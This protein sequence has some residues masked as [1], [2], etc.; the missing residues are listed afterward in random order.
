[1]IFF[2]VLALLAPPELVTVTGQV[3]DDQ[4]GEPVARALVKAPWFCPGAELFT[5]ESGEFRFQCKKI[6]N[7]GDDVSADIGARRPGYQTARHLLKPS[8]SE[9]RQTIR[10]KR[11]A[12]IAG[13]LKDTDG[14]P[15]PGQRVEALEIRTE[16]GRRTY[17]QRGWCTSDDKGEFRLGE[18]SAGRYLVRVMGREGSILHVG[19]LSRLV[20]QDERYGPTTWPNASRRAEGTP[21]RIQWGESHRLEFTL[22][23]RPAFVVRGRIEGYPAYKSLTMRLLIDGEEDAGIRPTLNVATGEF[24]LFDV[25]PGRYELEATNPSPREAEASEFGPTSVTVGAANVGG[26]ALRP[27]ELSSVALTVAGC[28]DPKMQGTIRLSGT[29]RGSRRDNRIVAGETAAE[30]SRLPRGPY[31][32][33]WLPAGNCYVAAAQSSGV[34][35]LADGLT[36]EAGSEARPLHVQLAPG[37]GT[38]HGQLAPAPKTAEV[39][40]LPVEYPKGLEPAH[41]YATA[42]GDFNFNGIAPGDYILIA[43]S[44]EDGEPAYLEPEVFEVLQRLGKRVRVSQGERVVVQVAPIP[45]KDIP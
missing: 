40:L 22:S 8:E 42:E 15:I 24:A 26:V 5:S 44:A 28:P 32:L 39:A 33:A 31:I 18:L 7:A 41:T 1:V 27:K 43:W 21:I 45:A 23:L 9:N 29:T 6:P 37:G 30:L 25:A 12:V 3:V 16:G 4:T 2:A 35:V 19:D 36:V 14:E 17:R 20:N 13:R 11:L 38:L 34:N 10:L